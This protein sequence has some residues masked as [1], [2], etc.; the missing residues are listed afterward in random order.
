MSSTDPAATGTPLT[1]HAVLDELEFLATVEHALIV[2]CL[3]V[4]YALGY[5]LDPGEGGPAPGPAAD[6]ASAASIQAQVHEMAHFRDISNA[7]VAAGR[8]ARLD[9]AARLPDDPARAISLD[10]PDLAELRQLIT[11]EQ[12]IAAAVDARYVKL[13][14]AVTSA[15]VFT[16]DPGPGGAT[17]LGGLLGDMR[18]VIIDHGPVH[19]AMFANMI[20][21]LSGLAPEDYLRATRR[22]TADSFEQR[23][24]DVSDRAYGVVLGVLR[25]QFGPPPG[26]GSEAVP[27]MQTLDDINRLLAQRGL[28]PPFTSS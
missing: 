16:D 14:P 4:S 26:P 21:S 7:L 2:E 15:P 25:D 3:T 19:A 11:R 18:A 24:L 12:A 5:D 22:D 9:R 1:Q 23:L 10:P 28:L 6:A 27:S 20:A 13:A 17:S 8:T